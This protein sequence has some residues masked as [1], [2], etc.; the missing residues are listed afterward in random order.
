MGTAVAKKMR[1]LVNTE[2]DWMNVAV[3]GDD[4]PQDEWFWCKCCGTL[5]C[6]GEEFFEP[7]SPFNKDNPI[8]SYVEPPCPSKI[9][10]AKG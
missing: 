10:V 5:M 1:K 8:G 7:G 2:H 6:N 3:V 9:R 4:H